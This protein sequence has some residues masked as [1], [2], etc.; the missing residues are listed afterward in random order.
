M[1]NKNRKT[2][3]TILSIIGF[4]FVF[5]PFAKY[6][7]PLDVTGTITKEGISFS[8]TGADATILTIG[9]VILL[10]AYF[11]YHKKLPWIK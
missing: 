2:I 6:L 3:S 10:L 9:I 4:I 11:V 8:F 1:K 7:K 5:V